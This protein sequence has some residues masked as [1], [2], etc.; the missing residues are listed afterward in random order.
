VV[1]VLAVAALGAL[2]VMTDRRADRADDRVADAADRLLR[3]ALPSDVDPGD[4]DLADPT[5]QV[6][7]ELQCGATTDGEGPTSGRYAVVTGGAAA[8][9]FDADL[10]AHELRALEET[11]DCGSGDDGQGWAEVTEL[12]DQGADVAVGRLACWVDD[13]GDAVLS[14]TW[15]DLGTR[16]VVELRGGGQDGLSTLRS[17]WDTT[18]DRGY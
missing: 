17:W 6:V 2:L 13:D 15:P 3:F 18:A 11:Y 9:A 4:C 1:V 16:A 5:G 10:A 7:R 14:W 8:D 12:D